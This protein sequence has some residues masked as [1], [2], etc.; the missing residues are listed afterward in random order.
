MIREVEQIKASISIVL[1]VPTSHS[2]L[3]HVCPDKHKLLFRP[4]NEQIHLKHTQNVVRQEVG[5]LPAAMCWK[6]RRGETKAGQ[7]LL[8][9]LQQVH[10]GKGFWGKENNKITP[11]NRLWRIYQ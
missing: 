1:L 7:N 10:K 4:Y 11:K 3:L 8:N 6:E 2:N 9:L 5:G